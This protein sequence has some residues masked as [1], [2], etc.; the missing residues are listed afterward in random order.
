MMGKQQWTGGKQDM[1]IGK[2]YGG[3]QKTLR[4]KEE[5]GEKDVHTGR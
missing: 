4:G 3:K 2:A 1:N 5:T